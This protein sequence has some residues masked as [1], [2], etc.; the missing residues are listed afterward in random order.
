MACLLEGEEVISIK[1][2]ED[3]EIEEEEGSEEE[4]EDGD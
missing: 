2:P 4:T 3:E 1:G